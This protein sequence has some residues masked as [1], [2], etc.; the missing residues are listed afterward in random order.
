MTNITGMK[1]MIC[2]TD[3]GYRVSFAA[4]RSRKT[5]DIVIERDGTVTV[6]AARPIFPKKQV[7]QLWRSKRYWIYRNLAE[8]RD[9]NAT[10]SCGNG[11]MAK[12]FCTWAARIDYVGGGSSGRC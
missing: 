11:S 2:K 6:R 1:A 7:E 10:A 4:E 5:A 12:G 9:L 3:K 8:W